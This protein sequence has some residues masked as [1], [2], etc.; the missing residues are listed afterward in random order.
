MKCANCNKAGD[1][2][3]GCSVCQSSQ[4][5]SVDCQKQHWSVH[6]TE[7]TSV[8]C[9]KLIE[10]I[11]RDDKATV[12]RLAKTKRVLNGKVDYTPPSTERLPDPYTMEGWTALHECVRQTNVDM[13]KIL[14][15]NGAKLE[16]KDVDGETPLF[17]AATSSSP[18]LLQTLLSGGANPNAQ[19]GDGWTALMMS[20]R[21]GSYE[22]TKLL[23]EAGANLYLGRDMFG[24][25]ALDISNSTVS[26]Q[27]G[28]RMS[29][30][31]THQEAMAKH[32]KVNELLSRWASRF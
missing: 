13:M 7:C 17:V 8:G 9:L 25:T 12:E 22:N 26:G 6:K 4:Y 32:M 1:E 5:C 14:V 31:E 3:R 2:L 16:V 24:R 18:E 11:Q 19:G 10:A 20:A 23:L 21:D 29:Q 27:V 28:L 15:K 30:G